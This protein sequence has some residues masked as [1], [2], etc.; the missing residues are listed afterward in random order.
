MM[1]NKQ[2]KKRWY[3]C[4]PG[5]NTECQKRSCFLYGGPCE[6]T[7]NAIYGLKDENGQPIE[8]DPRERLKEKIKNRE[9]GKGPFYTMLTFK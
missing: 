1:E 7:S 4:D 3:I 8:V 2:D 5:V 9:E 6:L